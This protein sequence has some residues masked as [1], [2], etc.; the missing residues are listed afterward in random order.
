M[1]PEEIEAVRVTAM[2]RM[3]DGIAYRCKIA[4]QNGHK[5]VSQGSGL[6]RCVQCNV[7][8]FVD[9]DPAFSSRKCAP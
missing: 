1:T 8:G 9:S 4:R 6:F 2:L 3:P 7:T 5:L